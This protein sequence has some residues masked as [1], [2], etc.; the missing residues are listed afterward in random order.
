MIVNLPSE[1]LSTAF[2]EHG[3]SQ[4]PGQ[5]TGKR[6]QRSHEPKALRTR[7]RVKRARDKGEQCTGYSDADRTVNCLRRPFE[8]L[9]YGVG[10]QT[11]AGEMKQRK[12][13]TV[14]RL[15]E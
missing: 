13:D 3:L 10:E 7:A 12:G 2:A 8:A 1:L 5:R 6:A 14:Q 11:H 4:L 9:R 15:H